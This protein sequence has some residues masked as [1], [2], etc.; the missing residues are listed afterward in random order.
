M[1]TKWFQLSSWRAENASVERANGA[2]AEP[3]PAPEESKPMNTATP[4]NSGNSGSITPANPG[5]NGSINLDNNWLPFDEVYRS[6]GIKTPRLG[7]SICKIVEML[8]NEHIR[9]LPTETKRASLL[10]ALDAAGV[11]VDEVLQDSTLRQRALNSYEAIQQKHLEEYEARKA[12]ENRAIQAEMDRVNAEYMDRINR[13]LDEVAHGKS[14]FHKWQVR[15]QQEIQRIAEAAVLCVTPTAQA[16]AAS[17]SRDL[18]VVIEVNK[19]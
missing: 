3:R 13:N 11:P 6:A 19:R 1:Q 15:K 10:M 12:Q 9:T 2:P 14:A 16:D 8:Q 18:A 7:Y 4:A 17:T 5:N